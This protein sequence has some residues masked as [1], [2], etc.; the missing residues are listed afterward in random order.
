MTLHRFAGR[1]VL[2]A[3]FTVLLTPALMAQMPDFDKDVAIKYLDTAK[4]VNEIEGFWDINMTSYVLLNDTLASKGSQNP[5]TKWFIVKDGYDADFRQD[6]DFYRIDSDETGEYFEYQGVLEPSSLPGI[7]YVYYRFAGRLNSKGILTL[8]PGKLKADIIYPDS[9]VKQIFVN[10]YDPALGVTITLDGVKTYPEKF[11]E[12]DENGMTVSYLDSAYVRVRDKSKAVYIRKVKLNPVGAPLGLCTLYFMNGQPM[13][14][15]VMTYYDPD[16]SKNDIPDGVCRTWYQ[17]GNLDSKRTY[18]NGVYNDTSFTW[19]E[20]GRPKSEIYYTN[21]TFNGVYNTWF[22]DGSPEVIGEF[23]DGNLKGNMY[24]VFDDQG[25]ERTIFYEGFGTNQ[26]G[27]PV[28][29]SKDVKVS[30]DE[31]IL[32]VVSDSK[33]NLSPSVEAPFDNQ[34]NYEIECSMIGEECGEDIFYGIVFG[35]KDD[36]NFQ[37]FAYNNKGEFVAGE[38]V[39]GKMATFADPAV[40]EAINRDDSNTLSIRTWGGMIF[41]TINKEDVYNT[42][43]KDLPGKGIGAYISGKGTFKFDEL[44][45]V[46]NKYIDSSEDWEEE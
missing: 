24:T 14:E 4:V 8:S 25:Q 1:V 42:F 18:I 43:K 21:G 3:L 30:L 31:G 44:S 45:V 29:D 40:S 16:D 9:I 2:A 12:T 22:E 32:T 11:D 10:N 17:N 5:F 38:Y 27:W 39:N 13:W 26:L 15:A 46:V 23:L 7:Y 6:Y 28:A 33:K 20:N 34:W 36:K 19:Y 41:Y 37:F 35:K